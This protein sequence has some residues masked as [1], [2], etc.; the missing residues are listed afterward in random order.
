MSSEERSNI[1]RDK[2]GKFAELAKSKN[3]NI[4]T[5]KS[6]CIIAG[7]EQ[8]HKNF[9][10]YPEALDKL[11]ELCKQTD[12]EEIFLQKVLLLAGID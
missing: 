8:M 5:I 2:V 11:I 1:V 12:D 7:S 10:D 6:A 9:G 3:Y 4:D